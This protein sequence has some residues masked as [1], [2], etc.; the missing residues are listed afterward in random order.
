MTK[1]GYFDYEFRNEVGEIEAETSQQTDLNETDKGNIEKGKYQTP[2]P[3]Y[4]YVSFKDMVGNV[5]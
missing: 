5:E 2:S 3:N 4:M 1:L